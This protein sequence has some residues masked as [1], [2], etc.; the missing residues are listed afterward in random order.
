MVPM[1]CLN[2]VVLACALVM[3]AWPA[4]AQDVVGR[5]G[6]KLRYQDCLQLAARN[7]PAAYGAA[8]KWAQE[9]GGSPAEHC[10]AV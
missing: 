8:Q 10:A 7:P 5:A 1:P 6:E 2:R 4:L 3:A 9:K